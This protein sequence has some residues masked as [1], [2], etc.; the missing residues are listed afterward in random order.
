MKKILMMLAMVGT[1]MLSLVLS[2][3]VLAQNQNPDKMSGRDYSACD[4]LAGKTIVG[5]GVAGVDVVNNCIAEVN[6]CYD[7][8]VG[9]DRREKLTSCLNG[10]KEKFAVTTNND[11]NNSETNP[12]V[13][14]V[15]TTG[16]DRCG[17]NGV[18]TS[19]LGSGGCVD[20]GSDGAGIFS[21]LNLVLNI[22]TAGV[23]IAA[24]IG[25]VVSGIQYLTAQDND[26]QVAKAKMR[27]F[28]IVIGL[29]VYAT[30]WAILSW[31]LPGGALNGSNT[32]SGS[33]SSSSAPE[34]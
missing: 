29:F 20:V 16:G 13:G 33:S 14:E 2:T 27:M 10:L 26:S 31:L 34:I 30:M 15:G 18:E 11:S 5:L 19:I 24:T 12:T 32:G 9:A 17:S 4:G 7:S 1:V 23:G 28:Q 22:L 8:N 3:P 25:F 21:I 6:K